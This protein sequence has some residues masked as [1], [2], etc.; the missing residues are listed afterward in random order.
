MT[1]KQ[2]IEQFSK[3]I[4]VE[5]KR[6]NRVTTNNITSSLTVAALNLAFVN[7]SCA[8]SGK[9][10][11]SQVIYRKIKDLKN[12]DISNC[13]R[14]NVLKFLKLLKIFSRNRKYLVSFDTTKEAFYGNPQKTSEIDRLYLHEGSIARESYYYYEYMTA[15]ITCSVNEKIILDGMIV[16]IGFYMEDYVY[17]MIG[18]I[19][20]I[21]NVELY[22]FDRGFGSWGMIYNLNKLKVNYLLFWRKQ[23]NWYKEY[24]NKL[25]DGE[26]MLINRNS[27]YNRHKS[28]HK[29]NANFILIKEFEYKSKKFS[30]IFAT[31]LDKTNSLYY[32]KRYKKRWG[33]ETIY[34]VTDKI[35]IYTTSTNP[36]IRYF[37]FMFTCFVYNIWR[38]FQDKLSVNLTLS[39]FKTNYTIFMAKIGMIY[40]RHYDN[41][42]KVAFGLHKI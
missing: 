22:L 2:I 24:F 41:F 32:I 13:F 28:R 34:R 4:L 33:I 8:S 14:N 20:S 17:N 25:D 31:N 39:N 16:P 6:K 36:V 21:I 38:Y 3:E 19:K 29:T 40:P 37:L 27:H 18:F 30:W 15:A 23:G 7:E 35:R 12:E 5:K 11:K 26:S 9:I 10:S 42:E 1:K